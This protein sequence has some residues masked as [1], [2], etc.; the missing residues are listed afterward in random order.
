M[1]I[2]MASLVDAAVL[3]AIGLTAVGLARKR[4]AAVRHAMLAA[5]VGAAVLMRILRS[6]GLYTARSSSLSRWRNS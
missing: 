5:T 6:A 4:S 2:V 3:L 1:T